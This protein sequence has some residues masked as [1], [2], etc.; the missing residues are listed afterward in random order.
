ME[1][2]DG[3]I[4]TTAAP[5]MGAALHVTPTSIGLVITAYLVTLAVLIPLS[6]WM[7]DRFGARPVF[8]SAIVIF[9]LASL[10]CAAA[11]NLTE[12]VAMRVLQ[13]VGGA[14]MVPVGRMVV[15]QRT[16]KRQLLRVMSF[17]VWPALLAPVIAPLLGG[18]ITT[19]ASW[20]W[21]FLI[22][23]PLGVI[24]LAFAW[25]L[26]EGEPNDEQRPL[27]WVGVLLACT[28]LGGLAFTAH[29]LSEPSTGW[30]E[31]AWFGIPAVALTVAAVWHL[32]HAPAP[33]IR[34]NVLRVPTFRASVG[35]G[36]LFWIAV[37]ATPFLLPLLFQ[38]EFGWS[39]IKSGALVLFVFIGNIGIKPATTPLLRWFGFR[40][41]LI[42]ATALLAATM[43]AM[44]LVTAG[45]P[46]ALIA[47][48][49]LVSGIARSVGLTGYVSVG[50]SEIPPERI[51][52]A[53]TLSA[54]AMQLSIGFGIA[55]ATVA[56]RIG[57]G[58]D[59]SGAYTIAFLILAGIA[60]VAMAGATRL[61]PS[62][63]DEVRAGAAR[64]ATAATNG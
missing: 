32:T 52:N 27:D 24:A 58:I 17:I 35:G 26:I 5:K 11:S 64:P 39:A 50:L 2:L 56:L 54:T 36:S 42:G 41:V 62:A 30:G 16:E 57:E 19:Y 22:N 3:T 25:R 12:L 40:R 1:N 9:T 23:V 7:V 49:A 55:A 46:L 48:I 29:L 31:V 20:P 63:G 15:L 47:A 38:E 10:G 45:T 60:L 13:G 28:G 34:L 51:N 18:V 8:L 6:G 61:H 43:V 4:V 21:L 14:M 37:G 33:L 44:A 53:N 59:D